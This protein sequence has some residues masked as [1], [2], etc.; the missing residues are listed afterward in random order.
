MGLFQSKSVEEKALQQ[1]EKQR[2][3]YE[4]FGLDIA[5]Y[6][7]EQLRQENYR[8]IQR[9]STELAGSQWEKLALALKGSAYEGFMLS[10]MSSLVEQNWILI[11]QNELILR[12]LEQ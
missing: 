11:R 9:I 4:K 8:N 7:P 2:K 6:S 10:Y 3:V 1:E 12:K 5:G